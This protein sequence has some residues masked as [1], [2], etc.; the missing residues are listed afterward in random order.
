[1]ASSSG[2]YAIY[3]VKLRLT[4]LQS[5]THTSDNPSCIGRGLQRVFSLR[6]QDLTPQKLCWS[7]LDFWEGV[8]VTQSLLTISHA[9]R[10]RW[11][12][13]T[14]SVITS[15]SESDVF[16]GGV[17]LRLTVS[18]FLN[19]SFRCHLAAQDGLW[20]L[21]IRSIFLSSSLPYLQHQTFSWQ[22]QL[23]TG[24]S[25][26]N[27]SGLG[28]QLTLQTCRRKFFSTSCF[29]QYNIGIGIVLSATGFNS[30][31]TALDWYCK[32][33]RLCHLAHEL[34]WPQVLE[35]FDKHR[36]YSSQC[37]FPEV[38]SSIAVDAT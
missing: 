36:N 12:Y 38:H 17:K 25:R 1:M 32:C 4:W 8:R 28:L 34:R 16:C 19:V 35:K 27:S 29:L 22:L 3:W 13:S 24:W 11:G 18:R 21:L 7:S 31:L 9:L 5:S 14:A 30:R 23:N 37:P 2:L 20:I 10:I 33:A 6:C 15:S 26:R